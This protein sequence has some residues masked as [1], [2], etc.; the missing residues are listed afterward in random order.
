MPWALASGVKQAYAGGESFKV[1]ARSA[2]GDAGGDHDGGGSGAGAGGD[3]GG[4]AGG[5]AGGGGGSVCHSGGSAFGFAR[6]QECV[7]LEALE[8]LWLLGE[9]DYFAGSAS[10]HFSVLARLWGVGRHRPPRREPVGGDGGAGHGCGGGGCGGRGAN[11]RVP[12]AWDDIAGVA[13]GLLATGFLHGKLNG[14]KSLSGPPSERM[15]VRSKQSLASPHNHA[16]VLFDRVFFSF[17]SI[18]SCALSPPPR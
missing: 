14:T 15:R 17:G 8:D 4:A 16:A 1:R 12:A 9:A 10:S 7:R 5:G 6:D 11:V 3:G 13:S 2:A 18:V